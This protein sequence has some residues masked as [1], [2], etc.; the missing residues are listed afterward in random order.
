MEGL[1]QE[2][3]NEMSMARF[4]PRRLCLRA[5]G[6]WPLWSLWPLGSGLAAPADVQTA[7]PE[8]AQFQGVPFQG[9]QL[10]LDWPAGRSPQGF[11]ISEKFDGVRALWDGRTLRFRSGRTIAAP[12]AFL[13]TL[14]QCALDGELWLAHGEFDRLSALVRQQRGAV[15]AWGA[16]IYQVFD[17]P[18]MP[19]PFEARWQALQEVLATAA[20]PGLRAVEQT[21]LADAAALQQRLDEVV[22][23]GGEGLMLHRADAPFVAGRS[24]VLLKLKPRDD[25]EAQVIA[26]VEGRGRLQGRLGALRVRTVDGVVFHIGSGLSDALRASPPPVGSW[27]T[28]TH[29]GLTERGVP[30]FAT[31]LRLRTL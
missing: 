16:V 2:T 4:A 21:R 18:Q 22:R 7:Q 15:Q 1:M 5:L 20:Q 12:A 17:A 8:G 14:P 11:L 3:A 6:A 30:R 29:R 27:V 13:Q 23:S 10:A 31:Y 19:G 28:Y 9:V 25:A 26:H 24:S